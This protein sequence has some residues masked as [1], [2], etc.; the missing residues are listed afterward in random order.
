MSTSVIGDIAQYVKEKIKQKMIDGK[1]R[2]AEAGTLIGC[3]PSWGYKLIKTNRDTKE[4][5]RL[6]IDPMAAHKVRECFR[7]YAEEQNLF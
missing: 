4:P 7:I 3:Y 2:K 1:Y 5:A 6:E